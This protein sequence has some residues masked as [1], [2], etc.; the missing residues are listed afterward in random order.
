MVPPLTPTPA[1]MA[2]PG[3]QEPV[4]LNPVQT[5]DL[6]RAQKVLR[7]KRETLAQQQ[8][9][10]IVGQQQAAAREAS[11]NRASVDELFRQKMAQIPQK[12]AEIQGLREQAGQVSP[13]MSP[14]QVAAASLLAILPA[15]VAY[16]AK[17]KK[18]VG[19]LAGTQDG[20]AQFMK[21]IE[22]RNAA[23]RAGAEL[24]L[25]GA[26]EELKELTDMESSYTSELLKEAIQQEKKV[27]EQ[28]FDVPIA[29]AGGAKINIGTLPGASGAKDKDDNK[30]M[31]ADGRAKWAAGMALPKMAN[32]VVAKLNWAD[33][34]LPNLFPTDSP[35]VQVVNDSIA[36][37]AYNVLGEIPGFPAALLKKGASPEEIK[38]TRGLF[39]QLK[40]E[41]RSLAAYMLKAMQ[42][43][44]PSD[45]D[46]KF[47]L[48]LMTG[49]IL[50]RPRDVATLI[51]QNV[52]RMKEQVSEEARLLRL[53]QE[54]DPAI[55]DAILSLNMNGVEDLVDDLALVNEL[56]EGIDPESKA[57]KDALNMYE[58]GFAAKNI[59]RN[60]PR[61]TATEKLK[62]LSKY[63][64][65]GTE[66]YVRYDDDTVFHKIVRV[67]GRDEADDKGTGWMSWNTGD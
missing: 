33:E 58:L 34:F 43:S 17:G 31:T 57:G 32:K 37:F 1:P 11:A 56:P 26:E 24:K 8:L 25:K 29:E 16:G 50:A 54:G 62:E 18:G 55:K 44:R 61:A 67:D 38:K 66:I 40:Q 59:Y 6:E 7:A 64:F 27:F 65:P 3:I 42:G 12:R 36:G 15:L 45:W 28:P 2:T 48:K 5:V 35:G 9:D 47:Y 30:W 23:G 39:F 49:G 46:L 53:L 63:Y 60:I 22:A 52:E 51:S 13:G 19:K 20:S 21:E 10:A 41:G 14:G 4:R